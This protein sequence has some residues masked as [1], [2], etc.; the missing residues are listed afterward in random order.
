MI[1]RLTTLFAGP[2]AG[3]FPRHQHPN[4]EEVGAARLAA[5]TASSVVHDN[6]TFNTKGC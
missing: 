4:Q 6:T 2:S 1:K 3:W 5:G